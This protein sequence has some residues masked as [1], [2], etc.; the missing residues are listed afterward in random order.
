VQ[1]VRSFVGTPFK[2]QGRVPGHGL[3]CVGIVVVAGRELGLINEDDVCYP[4][5]PDGERLERQLRSCFEEV[6][7]SESQAGD[8]L[9]FW[10]NKR[11]RAPQHVAVVTDYGIVHAHSGNGKVVEHALTDRWRRRIVRAYR[12]PGV[13]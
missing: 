8:I 6:P 1:L 11:T 3:D 9:V 4:R 2:H 10:I 7:V 12:F 13:Q 5:V